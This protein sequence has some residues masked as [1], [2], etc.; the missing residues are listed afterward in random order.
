MSSG[1]RENDMLNRRKFLGTTAAAAGVAVIGTGPGYAAE[2]AL[3]E[4]A[5]KEGLVTWYCSLVQDQASRPLA[6]AFQKKYP[7]VELEL[8]AGKSSDLFLKINDELATG[9]LQ[10]DVHHGGSTA[11]K[12]IKMDELADYMPDS[13]NSFPDDMKDV[14]GQWA[15]QVVSFLVPAY[16]TDMISAEDAPKSYEDLL[17]P[18]W[19]GAIAWAA[20]M[21][22]G[23]P[24]GFIGTVLGMM[25]EEKGM[26]YLRKLSAQDLVNIPANQR[27]VLDQVVSGEYPLAICT[28]SHHSE[29]SKK[30]GAPVQ[31][32][33]LAPQVTS[34]VDPCF[35]MKK[36]PHPNA[37]KLLIDFIIS[38]EGQEILG[39]AGYN[40]GNPTF[41]N[42]D[43]NPAAF[44]ISPDYVGKNISKWVE[45]YDE[46][47]K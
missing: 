32:I 29:I 5:R 24:P 16:N 42:P 1:N 7:G 27:V 4:S 38:D 17:D 3:V 9:Q 33:P 41:R 43:H 14:N 30:K 25:G 12:L 2:E 13:A 15:A 40:P 11:A 28:F 8:V 45:I 22:Q 36:A 34:T 39:K 35:L 47:F 23:G 10:A 37:G 20:S 21:T 46:L 26:E 44:A 18:K 31:W 6:A 19:R